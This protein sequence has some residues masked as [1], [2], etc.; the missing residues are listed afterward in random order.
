MA[1]VTAKTEPN[2]AVMAFSN[3]FMNLD[4]SKCSRLSDV[5]DRTSNLPFQGTDCSLPMTWALANKIPVDAFAV[6][7][8]N[9]TYVG[10]GHPS[11]RLRQYREQMNIPAKSA[12]IA[13]TANN[14]TIADPNDAGMMDMAGL[15]TALPTILSDFIR[16]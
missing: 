11:Q 5:V 2:Y 16:D 9:E 12:V 7:T 13:F 1:M 14:F 8:D 15:D 10:S 6:F 4:I 3:T